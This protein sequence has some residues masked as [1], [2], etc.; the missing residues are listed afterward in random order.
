MAHSASCRAATTVWGDLQ[1][2]ADAAVLDVVRLQGDLVLKRHAQ[3]IARLI[4][5]STPD[6]IPV[7]AMGTAHQA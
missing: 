6:G 1:Q 4:L 5:I 3:R 2:Q 7:D